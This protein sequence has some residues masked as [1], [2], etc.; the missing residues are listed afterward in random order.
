MT[1]AKVKYRDWE[2]EVDRDL[3]RETYKSVLVS[4]AEDCF[5]NDCK[6][7]IS[8][9]EKIFPDEI[10][11]LF[12]ELGID[13]KKEVEITLFETLPNG[14]HHIAGLFHFK[15][16]ILTGKECRVPVQSG[17]YRLDLTAIANNFSIGFCKDSDLTYF[18][19]KAGLVQVEFMTFIPWVIDK[20]L[21][22]KSYCEIIK[23][24]KPSR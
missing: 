6:N 14:L 18:S 19:D 13:Y 10:R 16:R 7:Y 23:N 8:Y 15:G 1:M 12:D 22:K 9:R 5:C 4:G 3:T 20:S 11:Q 2:F 24:K 17:G 21:E